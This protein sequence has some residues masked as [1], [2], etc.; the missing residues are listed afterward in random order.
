MQAFYGC[1]GKISRQ[2]YNRKQLSTLI[3]DR[4]LKKRQ[5]QSALKISSPHEKGYYDYLR[6]E[7]ARRIVDRI[8][9]ITRPFPRALEIGS[10]NDILYKIIK[11]QESQF[12]GSAGGMGGIQKLVQCGI[13]CRKESSMVHSGQEE[14]SLVTTDYI[15]C[16]EESL[17]LLS[18]EF[19]LVVSSM[20]LHWINDLPKILNTIKSTLKPDGAFIGSMR[21]GNSL[22]ELK[23]CFY[24]AELERRGGYSPHVSPF[25]L[26]SDIAGLMQAAKFAMPTVDVDTI[27]VSN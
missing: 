2:L 4:G 17:S 21:G 10:Y 15:E 20:S 1:R 19:D 22:K 3:F 12:E 26:P 14:N 24:L 13:A 18:E 9:D 8:E 23:H 7:S 6:E 27:T 16:D 5:L 25:A 11:S